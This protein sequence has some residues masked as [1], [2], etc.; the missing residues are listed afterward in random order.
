[1]DKIDARKLTPS[2]RA[3]LRKMVV[4]LRQ[5]TRMPVQELAAVTGVH[6]RTVEEWLMRARL[7]GVEVLEKEKKRGRP[8]GACRKLTF[9]DEQ[10][11]RAQ[12]VGQ[13]PTSLQLPYTLWSR[14]AL[15][16]LI[17]ARTGIE[18]QDR[19]IGKYL[20]RWGVTTQRS[21]QQTLKENPHKGHT[22]LKDTWPMVV[23]RAQSEEAIIL[24]GDTHAVEEDG[25]WRQAQVCGDQQPQPASPPQQDTLSMLSATSMRGQILFMLFAE[26]L[27]TRHMR[28]F[29][30]QLLE[31]ATQKIFLIVD[32]LRMPQAG[33]V[34]AW[35]QDRT[36][37]IE[38]VFLPSSVPEPQSHAHTHAH[39][40]LSPLRGARTA[41]PHH[42]LTRPAMST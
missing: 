28:T 38:L 3:L 27:T 26:P 42:R 36:Q 32:P 8:I 11:I 14:S 29:L 22:W 35:L 13:S 40:Q 16:A 10:W 2:G 21:L 34:A 1:M 19:L 18:M 33:Q 6:V 30:M 24:W 12:M 41:E 31:G 23:A 5:Q 4:R 17:K 7:E 37:Q 20:K 15:K 25:Q 39:T 9:A